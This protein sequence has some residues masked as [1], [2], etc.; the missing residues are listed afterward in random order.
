MTEQEEACCLFLFFS[1][2]GLLHRG[3]GD[4]EDSDFELLFIL[5]DGSTTSV[6]VE[7]RVERRVEDCGL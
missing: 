1:F 5:F 3:L 4:A 7:R 2:F 6:V